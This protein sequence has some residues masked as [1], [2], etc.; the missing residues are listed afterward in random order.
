MRRL[1]DAIIAGLLGCGAYRPA[2]G[3]TWTSH[4]STFVTEHMVGV[5]LL[6]VLAI[7]GAVWVWNEHRDKP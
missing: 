7:V 2:M 3:P 1:A 4:L 5:I 6:G